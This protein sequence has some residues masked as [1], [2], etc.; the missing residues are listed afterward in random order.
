[1]GEESGTT[2]AVWHISDEKLIQWFIE[3]GQHAVPTKPFNLFPWCRIADP[4]LWKKYM[5][6]CA[7]A[8]PSV[9]EKTNVRFTIDLRKLKFFLEGVADL[10]KNT[11]NILSERD[12]HGRDSNT[13]AH[14]PPPSQPE[15][16]D[17]IDPSTIF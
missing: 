1:M 8:G 7:Y 16:G 12:E 6:S 17:R 14:V 11:T 2:E 5:I 9:E 15:D 13:D 10:H 4:E 3:K